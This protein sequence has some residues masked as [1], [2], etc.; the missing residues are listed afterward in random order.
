VHVRPYRRQ[1]GDPL[2]R[3]LRIFTLDPSTPRL[4]GAIALINVP[5]EPLQPGPVGALLEVD[6]RDGATDTRYR[7]VDLDDPFVLM[8]DGRDPSPSDP[9]F[10]QQM[11]YAVCSTVHAAFK[12]ALGRDLGW[13]FD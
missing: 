13:G 1:K 11:C 6:S 8:R 4:D 7:Q 3:H 10:H 9:M 12:T 5:Y 2:Y